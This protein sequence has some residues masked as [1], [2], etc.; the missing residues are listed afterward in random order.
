MNLAQRIVLIFGFVLLLTACLFPPWLFVYHFA[1][2]PEIVRPAGYHLILSEHTP[3][4][5]TALMKLFS[6]RSAHMEL[7]TMRIDTSRLTIEIV[8]ILLLTGLLCLALGTRR[9]Q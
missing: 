3:Q 5:P 6:M 7:F 2:Y 8:A 1:D 9:T 4:D